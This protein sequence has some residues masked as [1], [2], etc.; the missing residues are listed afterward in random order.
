MKRTKH[1]LPIPQ[2]E[3]G[4][5]PDTFNLIQESALDGERIARERE[6]A[7]DDRNQAEA[8]QAAFFNSTQNEHE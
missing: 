1:R 6:Q 5:T 7:H 8:G 4:F 3:F 2:Q